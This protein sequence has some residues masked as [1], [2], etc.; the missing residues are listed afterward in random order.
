MTLHRGATPLYGGL[1][2]ELDHAE[3]TGEIREG[4]FLQFLVGPAIGALTGF[5]K[6][7]V[8]G[9][10]VTEVGG[11]AFAPAAKPQRKKPTLKQL[12]RREF[13]NEARS[14]GANFGEAQAYAAQKLREYEAANGPVA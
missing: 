10:G 3:S 14:D 5:F 9:S 1:L 11:E 12:M 8:T 6:N 7:L 4:G 13:F 2:D